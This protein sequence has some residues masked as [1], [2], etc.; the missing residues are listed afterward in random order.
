M[1]R[2]V[3]LGMLIISYTTSFSQLIKYRPILS[4]VT[5]K[6][7]SQAAASQEIEINSSF[8]VVGVDSLDSM[9]STLKIDT[10][11]LPFWDDFS[12]GNGIADT[13]R[14]IKDGTVLISNTIGISAPSIGVAVFDGINSLGE[15]HSNGNTDPQVTDSLV[16]QAIDLS[17]LTDNDDVVFSFYLQKQGNSDPIEGDDQ[18]K[19]YWLDSAKTWQLRENLVFSDTN[20]RLSN[21]NFELIDDFILRP[22]FLHAGFRIKFESVGQA[23]G[24]FDVWCIDQVSVDKNRMRGEPNRDA[25]VNSTPDFIFGE[26]SHIPVNVFKQSSNKSS[27]LSATST[28][29]FA[30]SEGSALKY[31][32]SYTDVRNPLDTIMTYSMV[33]S[34]RLDTT[35]LTS[36]P[37]PVDNVMDRF[38]SVA[39]TEESLHIKVE[40][41]IEANTDPAGITVNDTSSAVYTI[42]SLLA[43]DDGSAEIA[44][45]ISTV[46]DLAYRFNL[47]EGVTDTLIGLMIYFPRTSGAPSGE[48]DLKVWK[49]DSVPNETIV[50]SIGKQ[51]IAG[52][53][54]ELAY[55]KLPATAVSGVF[56]V[57]YHQLING[58]L[59]VGLDKNGNDQGQKAWFSIGDEDKWL[60]EQSFKGTLMIRPVFGQTEKGLVL[61]SEINMETSL[62]IFPHPNSSNIFKVSKVFESAVLFSVNGEY[63]KDFQIRGNL[64]DC[65]QVKTGVYFARIKVNN[66]I[67]TKKIIV[68]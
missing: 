34:N 41:A 12:Y 63:I 4:S 55:Y 9:V 31:K 8:R 28:T 54:D 35:L 13:N 5:E 27:L 50:S 6:I 25:A 10:L 36:I 42:D 49:G 66:S 3:L 30:P 64:L 26:Y 39:Y 59:G 48:I 46:G 32:Y 20:A 33:A 43:Y 68:L 65:S 44:A 11:A 40:C 15:P 38:D 7:L 18:F 60:Q 58:F 17:G 14:W 29:A 22:E 53:I 57:G 51:I 61:A 56:Y 52:D 16:S 23:T 19:V 37:L 21:T 67:I 2:I 62:F 24:P 45:G 47:P 1:R